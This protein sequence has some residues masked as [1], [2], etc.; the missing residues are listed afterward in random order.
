M[1]KDMQICNTCNEAKPLNMFPK[2]RLKCRACKSAENSARLKERYVNDPKFLEATK[3]RTATWQREN[4]ERSNEY[5]RRRHAKKVAEGDKVYLTKQAEASARYNKSKKGKRVNS[6]RMK[7]YEESGQAKMWRDARRQQPE[8]RASQML[9]SARNRALKF[10]I[11]FNLI[12]DDV[13]PALASGKCQKTGLPFDLERHP[14]HRVHPFA[15]SID[16]IS[17]KK[18]YIKGNVQIVCWAYNAARN[19]WGDEVLLR[20]ARAIVDTTPQ[21]DV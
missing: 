3:R 15:P 2:W 9:A 8:S 7:Q 16:R 18:G 20:L 4:A 19:Q 10:N 17:H 5:Q 11:E 13:Y 12:F 14:D 21:T 1:S 6:V